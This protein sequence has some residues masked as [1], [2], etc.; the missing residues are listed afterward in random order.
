VR[1]D[2]P[3]EAAALFLALVAN[4]LA[5]RVS[6]GEPPPDLDA[7]VQLVEEGVAPR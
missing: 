7:L 2:V 4:G 3:I 1:D 6:V 5:L